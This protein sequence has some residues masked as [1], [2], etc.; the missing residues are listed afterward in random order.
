MPALTHVHMGLIG[1]CDG[2]RLSIFAQRADRASV[3]AFNTA[4]KALELG[5]RMM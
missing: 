1:L 5:S 2:L 4:N 3:D